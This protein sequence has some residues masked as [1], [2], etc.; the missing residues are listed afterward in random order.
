M[1]WQPV[2][3][4]QLSSARHHCSCRM[5]QLHPVPEHH[6]SNAKRKSTSNEDR[7]DRESE[8]ER[9]RGDWWRSTKEKHKTT[10]S[11]S[12][13]TQWGLLRVMESCSRQTALLLL[14]LLTPSLIQAHITYAVFKCKQAPQYVPAHAH[15]ELHLRQRDGAY[16][17]KMY[18]CVCVCV[19]VCVCACG[20]VS[21]CVCVCVCVCACG[22][23]SVCVCVCV[24]VCVLEDTDKMFQKNWRNKSSPVK[25]H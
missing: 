5:I 23:V 25:L 11:I 19:R 16:S 13:V 8:R 9:E 18:V 24:C 10:Q 12:M 17:A 7:R 4:Q 15:W 20:C 1:S 6:R 2:Q 14:L 3:S 21:M 22:C